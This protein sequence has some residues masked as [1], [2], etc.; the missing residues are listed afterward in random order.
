[1]CE[2]GDGGGERGDVIRW[3][4]ADQLGYD[5]PRCLSSRVPVFPSG[6]GYG[7]ERDAFVAGV[8][9]PFDEPGLFERGDEDC[10]RRLGDSLD[11]R[12][13]SDSAGSGELQGGE[14]RRRGEAHVARRGS[15]D[16][17]QEAVERIG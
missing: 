9:L 8:A 15:D 1:M 3:Q 13:I 4:F 12:E 14:G 16:R 11:D 7:N 17:R 10:H 6:R 2:R 5:L